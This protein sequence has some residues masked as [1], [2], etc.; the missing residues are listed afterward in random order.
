VHSL[1]TPIILYD[2]SLKIINLPYHI[3]NRIKL[4]NVTK[5]IID[6]DQDIKFKMEGLKSKRWLVRLTQF[7]FICPNPN[8]IFQSHWIPFHGADC[9]Y[10]TILF[11]KMKEICR[12]NDH[13]QTT[14]SF[15]LK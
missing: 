12:R 3:K 5:N 7:V 14:I 2:H 13:D 9:Y 11:Q 8:S 1:A 6:I 10:E 4:N 15:E